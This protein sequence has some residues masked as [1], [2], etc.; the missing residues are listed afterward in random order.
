MASKFFKISVKD[1]H[2]TTS[3]SVIIT[4]DIPEEIQ[5]HFNYKQGQYITFKETINNEEVRRSY[6]LCSSPLDKEWKVGIKKVEDGRFSTFAN[7]EL[8]EGD[9]LM[10]MPPAGHFYTEV[11][12]EAQKNYIAFAAGSGITPILSII[13]THLKA[14]KKSTFKLFY[15]NQKVSSI[16]LK[17]EIEGL[18][19]SYMERFEIFH[20]LTKQSRSVPLFNGRMDKDKLEVIFKTIADYNTTD[21]FFSCGP[22]SMIFMIK[23][24]LTEKGVDSKKIHFELFGTNTGKQSQ[25]KAAI[26]EKLKGKPCDVTI[27]E[28]GKSYNFEIEQGADNLLDAA[29]NNDADMPFACKGGVCATCKAK[30]LEGNVDMLVSYGL[31]EEE[32]QKGYI[33]TCQAIPTCNKV[34]VDFDI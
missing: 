28:G 16:M 29:L 15:I 6:S 17:E 4:L 10:A 33:L 7:D 30:L 32:I 5:N 25:K 21:H 3:D 27:I 1:I 11:D 19:N 31:E 13:K 9:V 14:E 26:K 24:F 34:V 22:E 12:T 8:K 18:K 20:F 23:D 2:R